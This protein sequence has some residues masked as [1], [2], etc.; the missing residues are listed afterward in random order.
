MKPAATIEK[1]IAGTPLKW[2]ALGD[3]LTYG[4]MV[5]KGYLDFL[6]EMIV[7]KYPQAQPDIY[8]RGIPGD[9]AE[10]GLR[11][12][13]EHVLSL[14]PDIVSVQFGLNDLFVGYTVEQFAANIRNIISRIHEHSRCDILLM[15]SVAVADPHDNAQ[16][17]AFYN[18]IIDISQREGLP[19]ARVHECWER[20]IAS[21]R[22]WQE[23]VQAD[24]VHPT[25]EGYR[26]M[27]EAIMEVL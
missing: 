3:S 13:G 19:C 26:L 1:L 11:R 8:N 15:T 9:T 6:R 24:G 5:R 23:L 18:A 20:E 14:H 4:W 17:R 7:G 12:L 10:G 22:R 16:A 25:E 27:A 2:V 21:G